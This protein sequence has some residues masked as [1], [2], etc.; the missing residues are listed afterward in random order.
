[1]GSLTFCLVVSTNINYKQEGTFLAEGLLQVIYVQK[2][3][4]FLNTYI[5][6]SA[7]V[8]E[9]SGCARVL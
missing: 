5:V 7:A 6:V 8:A 4:C 1:M 2:Y 9:I 3:L